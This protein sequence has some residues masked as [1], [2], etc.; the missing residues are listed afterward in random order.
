MT[1]NLTKNVETPFFLKFCKEIIINA[2]FYS[3]NILSVLTVYIPA[4]KPFEI[5]LVF[6]FWQKENIIQVVYLHTNDTYIKN[7]ACIQTMRL[8]A[9]N[10]NPL[11]PHL[12]LS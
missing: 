7:H 8:E 12:A 4:K 11:L 6:I 1:R 3:S 10:W 5:L 9:T 2:S